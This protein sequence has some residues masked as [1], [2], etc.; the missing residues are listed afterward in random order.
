VAKAG[1]AGRPDVAAT[2][3]L[4]IRRLTLFSPYR[5]AVGYLWNSIGA[6]VLPPLIHAHGHEQ[7]FR[8]GI[9]RAQG[10]ERAAGYTQAKLE[11]CLTFR[12]PVCGQRVELRKGDVLARWSPSRRSRLCVTWI[13][14]PGPSCQISARGFYS[15]ISVTFEGGGSAVAGRVHP[16]IRED[17]Q[18]GALG[19][20]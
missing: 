12:S 4:S 2:G 16:G 15:V 17:H 20:P 11:F 18:R 13:R 6:K 7:G 14:R 8:L 3:R 9:E 1:L 5:V 19:T 10:V